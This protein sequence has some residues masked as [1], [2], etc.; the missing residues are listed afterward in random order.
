MC[1]DVNQVTISE[2]QW[3]RWQMGELIQNVAPELSP[4][5]RELLISGI[6]SECW[7]KMFGGK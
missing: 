7:N 4:E 1:G 5:E 6:C 2:A 3:W